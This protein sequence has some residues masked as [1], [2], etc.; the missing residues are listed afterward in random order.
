[1]AAQCL[2][3]LRLDSFSN[4]LNIDIRHEMLLNRSNHIRGNGTGIYHN[5]LSR[6]Q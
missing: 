4:C 6:Q 5:R 3:K 2:G 1:M